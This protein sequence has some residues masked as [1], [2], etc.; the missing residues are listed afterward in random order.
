[1]PKLGK[2]KQAEEANEFDYKELKAEHKKALKEAEQEP[3]LSKKEKRMSLKAERA[4]VKEIHAERKAL[5][6]GLKKQGIKKRSEFEIFASEVGLSYPEGTWAAAVA[7]TLAKISGVIGTAKANA[8]MVKALII[9][10]ILLLLTL[11][12]A[13]ITEEKGHFTVNV[14]ADMLQNG[15]QISESMDF[16]K[17]N[18]RL[19]AKEIQNSNATSINEINRNVDKV[20]GSHNGPGYMAYTFYLRNNGTETTDYAYTVNILSETMNTAA[21]TWVMFFEGDQVLDESGQQAIDEDGNPVWSTHHI[22]YAK[23]QENGKEENLY[24][25][26]SAPFRETS[27]D[28]SS[29]YYTRDGAVGIRTVPFIDDYTALQGYVQDFRPDEVKKYTV[30]IWLEGDDPDCNNSILGGHVGYNVQFDKIAENDRTFFKG[31][32]R[33]EFEDSFYGQEVTETDI[34]DAGTGNWDGIEN[35][36]SSQYASVTDA[37]S[38]ADAEP[39]NQTDN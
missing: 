25:Y 21:A 13:Y 3:P 10:L 6:K 14:T 28:P 35:Y 16:S 15:F 1:M 7:D 19:Y 8:T 20:D 22:I 33:K 11:Y 31:L 38:E 5:R 12:T 18:T 24:G 17:D 23:P 32:F 2:K 39:K 36:K 29:Q 34:S 37:D 26:P 27:Y 9:I 4:K 30:V